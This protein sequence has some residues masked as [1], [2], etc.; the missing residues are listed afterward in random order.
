MSILAVPFVGFLFTLISSYFVGNKKVIVLFPTTL[1]FIN[2]L[3]SIF[4][5]YKISYID[6]KATLIEQSSEN[7]LEDVSNMSETVSID[8]GG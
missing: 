2:V 3:T 6:Y 7:L 1:L 8:L 4:L 5:F